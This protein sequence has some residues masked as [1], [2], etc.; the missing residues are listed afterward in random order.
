MVQK[1]IDFFNKE[2][3]GLHQAAFLLGFSSLVSQL[4]GLFRDRLL[5][6]HF[7]ASSELDI[8]YAAFRL[9]DL[10]FVSVGSFLAVT[11]LIP[12]LVDK[13]EHESV[14][15]VKSFLSS[16]LTF[17]LLTIT[18]TSAVV[19][20][21][22]PYL[23]DFVA[24]GFDLQA[25]AKLITMTRILL[26]SPFF[27]GLSNLFG[28]VTQSY[29]RFFIYALSPV[30]YNIG[31]ISGV[32]F[33]YPVFG[34]DGL[35]YGVVLG[36]LMHFLVQVPTVVSEGYFPAISFKFLKKDISKISS[37]SL[38]RTMALG[39][40]VLA[41]M[42]L[43]ALASHMSSGSISIF[44]F[45]FNLQSVP[46]ALIGISYSVAAFPTMSKMFSSGQKEEFVSYMS[47]TLRHII[48]W[49]M[50]IV[51]LFI[52]LRAQIVRIIL[53]SGN[54]NW[55]HTRLTAALLAMFSLT[56]VFQSIIQLFDRAYYATGKTKQP[57]IIKIAS[58]L[59]IIISA[60]LFINISS[61]HP[62]YERLVDRVFRI[63]DVPGAE[64]LLLGLAFTIGTFINAI[65]L[66]ITFE[67]DIKIRFSPRVMK[68]VLQSLLAS[69]VLGIITSFS[70]HIFNNFLDLQTFWGIF[71]H[72]LY[73]GLIGIFVWCMFLT[74]IK[75]EEMRGFT[76]MISRKFGNKRPIIPSPEGL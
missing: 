38:P 61:G 56:V 25:K 43:T 45:A 26:L 59:I 49:S 52:V 6:G 74:A 70:L 69:I 40:N 76:S 3:S 21:F 15:D 12:I 41:I 73:S 18:I 9:P 13:I 24:P 72:G 14:E 42:V 58:S 20:I 2:F 60:Y 68:T 33:F 57:V 11:V 34:L 44:N 8:Y 75:N 23:V 1:L 19:Y 63:A 29:K 36:A 46:M 55:D 53:G 27:L 5:A 62:G 64:V 32:I 39:V 35:V 48:F 37:L 51:T 10:I 22:T 7:G 50:P 4:L 28:A 16:L 54:F 65:F 47:E 17:F 67:K 66:W 31:I 71:L 30:L